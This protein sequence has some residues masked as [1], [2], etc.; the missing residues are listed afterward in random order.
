MRELVD[1]DDD[2]GAWIHHRVLRRLVDAIA[3]LTWREVA[4]DDL[5]ATDD[6][7]VL[8]VSNHF[9][10]V[11]DALVLMSVLPRRPRILA[12]DA[13]W[14]VPVA[15]QVM[16][17]IG[18]IPVHRGHAGT[19]DNADMFA[20]AHEALADGELV[21]IF[22]EGIT[23]EEPS[24]GEVRSG[25][26]RIAI[27]ARARGVDGVRIVPVGLH[28][29]DKAAFRSVVYVREG[30]PID[31]DAELVDEPAEP[32]DAGDA[33]AEHEEVERLTELIAR[34]LRDTAPDYDDWREARALQMGAEA[35]L[36]SLDP[37]ESVPIGLRDRLG[38]WLARRDDADELVEVADRYRRALSH[39]GATDAWAAQ[40]RALLSRRRIV[41]LV[42][43]L[44][45]LPYALLGLVAWAV[46]AV[47]TWAVSRVRLA[48]AVMATVLP[49]AAFVLFGATSFGWLWW[50]WDRDRSTA[51]VTFAVLG[52]VTFTAMVLVIERGLLWTRWLR[53]RLNTLGGRRRHLADLRAEVVAGV[54]E[55]VGGSLERPELAS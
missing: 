39:A 9:G 25:A 2:P 48:P 43:W 22:P 37:D 12:D 24:I 1:P 7:P 27:G 51:V 14:K 16:E 55:R 20:A 52:P 44:L 42:T 40:G 26:A 4:I 45:M 49:L 34:R 28:Y 8:L 38:A 29:E 3:F 11:S 19:T 21:L 17:W 50:A 23:R 6:G 33:V 18:A 47:L 30:Q 41:T 53:N 46:P 35:F 54:A 10:G 5:E 13:I 31:L 15:K 32:A 36:R